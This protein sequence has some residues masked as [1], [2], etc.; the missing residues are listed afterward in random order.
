MHKLRVEAETSDRERHMQVP[1]LGMK[2][3]RLKAVRMTA[4]KKTE[5]LLNKQRK[6]RHCPKSKQKIKNKKSEK[7]FM[8]SLSPTCPQH[9]GA[10]INAGQVHV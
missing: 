3:M 7:S 2:A 1:S 10:C 8:D 9:W 5:R 4:A 6:E